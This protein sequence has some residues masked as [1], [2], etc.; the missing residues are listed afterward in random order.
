MRLVGGLGRLDQQVDGLPG[1]QVR[2][3]SQCCMIL[4]RP[5]LSDLDEE[6]VADY[7]ASQEPGGPATPFK[8]IRRLQSGHRLTVAT[9]RLDTR[10]FWEPGRPLLRYRDDA[11]I[12]RLTADSRAR[13]AECQP[14]LRLC[15]HLRLSD[16]AA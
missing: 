2:I 5:A 9:D 4:D 10:R 15:C 14:D 12:L 7:L 6:Y 11:V 13:T 16:R 8:G 1:R 3:A